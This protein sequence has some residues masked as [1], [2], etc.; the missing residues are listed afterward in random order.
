LADEELLGGAGEAA[1]LGDRQKDAQEVQIHLYNYELC[2]REKYIL[3]S[4]WR[5]R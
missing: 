4:Y 1:A 5:G 3:A 2:F